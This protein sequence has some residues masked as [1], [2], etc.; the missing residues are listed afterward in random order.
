M[1]GRREMERRH[2]VVCANLIVREK[3]GERERDQQDSVFSVINPRQ[4]QGLYFVGRE[5]TTGL[6]GWY[7]SCYG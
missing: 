2:E 1:G 4:S 7:Y 3:E 6:C 5:A